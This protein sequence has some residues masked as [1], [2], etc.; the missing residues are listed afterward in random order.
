VETKCGIRGSNGAWTIA[1]K[2]YGTVWWSVGGI[3]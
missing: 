3:C 1:T 2:S